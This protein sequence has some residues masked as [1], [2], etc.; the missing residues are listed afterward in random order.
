MSRRRHGTCPARHR[1]GAPP[2]NLHRAVREPLGPFV[3]V[4]GEH[5]RGACL[6]RLGD[7]RVDE[8]AGLGVETRVRFVEKP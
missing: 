2:D 6:D 4:A 1:V 5:H 3:L 7:Q 8:I